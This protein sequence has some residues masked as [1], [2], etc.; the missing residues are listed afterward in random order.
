M[1]IPNVPAPEVP[2]PIDIQAWIALLKAKRERYQPEIRG[3]Q[4]YERLDVP[5]SLP[6]LIKAREGY[7][8]TVA[9]IDAEIVTA[10]ALAK[11]AGWPDI[12]KIEMAPEEIEELDRELAETAE[13]RGQFVVRPGDAV[14]ARVVSETVRDVRP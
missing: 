4:N 3:I 14:S 6:K 7:E 9:A 13:S 10:E 1:E 12:P 11:D 8:A 2:T 5:R